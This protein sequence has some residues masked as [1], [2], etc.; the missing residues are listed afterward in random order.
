MPYRIG[1][2]PASITIHFGDRRIA[3]SVLMNG[4]SLNNP[5]NLS[6]EDYLA[7]VNDGT[8]HYFSNDLPEKYVFT[9]TAI[10]EDFQGFDAQIQCVG[11]L[12]QEAANELRDSAA[13]HIAP[14]ALSGGLAFDFH[15]DIT[16]PQ[17]KTTVEI[18]PDTLGRYRGN[19]T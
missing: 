8:Y 4:E 12:N 19:S 9:V 15:L 7:R 13:I 1:V 2:D 5:D 6:A 3:F 10:H 16:T 17:V 14:E 18:Q 11:D